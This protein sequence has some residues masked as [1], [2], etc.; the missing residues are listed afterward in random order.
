MKI[1]I[2]RK[3]A[4]QFTEKRGIVKIDSTFFSFDWKSR[5]PAVWALVCSDQ[6]LLL[7]GRKLWNSLCQFR[8]D[9]IERE[10]TKL[11]LSLEKVRAKRATIKITRF[12]GIF[13]TMIKIVNVVDDYFVWISLYIVTLPSIMAMNCWKKIAW[14]RKKC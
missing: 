6:R 3:K 2:F 8:R 7:R 11:Q 14:V 5:H 9:Y 1:Y 4:L 13:E 10:G 12:V